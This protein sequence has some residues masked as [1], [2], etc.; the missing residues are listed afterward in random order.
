MASQEVSTRP[1]SR[2]VS[3]WL[4]HE[5]SWFRSLRRQ[6][7]DLLLEPM[8]PPIPV[9]ERRQSFWRR[10]RVLVRSQFVSLTLHAALVAGLVIP[11]ATYISTSGGDVAGR[12]WVEGPLFYGPSRDG[13]RPLNGRRAQGGGGGGQFEQAPPTAG[14]AAELDWSQVV[15]PILRIRNPKPKL[16]A[17]MTLVGPPS[18]H[19]PS[20]LLANI[21][22]PFERL[23]TGSAGPGGPI[24]V[25]R[26]DG[27]GIGDDEGP[28]AGP[29]SGGGTGGSRS[30]RGARLFASDPQCQYC[31]NPTF[32]DEARKAKHQGIV[33]LLV[34]VSPEGKAERIRILTG[35]GLGLDERAIE[36]VKNWV[37]RPALGW[38]GKPIAAEVPIEVAFRLL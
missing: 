29:G 9:V 2:E 1:D 35:L 7:R 4:L 27:T 28:G 36:A 22:S 21:G 5:E 16:D 15:P 11:G 6:I 19:L 30:N 38:D 33:V 24:G 3:R 14:R 32:T 34:V 31:P 8:R 13:K 37:F 26:G 20:S 25:G 18:L 10:E 23:F 12:V 17:E